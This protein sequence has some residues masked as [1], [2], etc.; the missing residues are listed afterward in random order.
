MKIIKDFD[1]YSPQWLE[2]SFNKRNKTYGAYELRNDSSNRHIKAIVI[3]FAVGLFAIFLPRIV[4]TMSFGEGPEVKQEDGVKMVAVNQADEEEKPKEEVRVEE[5]IPPPIVKETARVTTF[6]V[7]KDKDVDPTELKTATEIDQLDVT[8]DTKDQAGEKGPILPDEPVTSPVVETVVPER[9]PDIKAEPPGGMAAL[10]K[11]LGEQMSYPQDAAEAN[12]FGTVIVEFVVKAD[13]T[14]DNVR[15][16]KKVHPSLDNEAIRVVKKMERWK[17][18]K[19][20][21]IA[22]SSYF[23]LPVQFKL[24]QRK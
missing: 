20:N 19:T 18:G 17:A 14:V 24:Q 23:Q 15:V 8:F 6:E 7:A 12:V 4:E 10:Q 2:I 5:A 16:I 11:W 13:G 3:V 9:F 1:L 21:N 22:V